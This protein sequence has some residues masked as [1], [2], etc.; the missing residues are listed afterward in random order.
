MDSPPFGP[1]LATA[2]R[3]AG[4]AARRVARRVRFRRRLRLGRGRIRA[5]WWGIAQSAV[6]GA[7]AWELAERPLH[8]QAPFFASVAAIVCLSTSY[9]NRLRR[10]IEMGI[11]V[12][13]GVGLGDLLVGVIGHGSIQLGFTV[14]IA[15]TVALLLDGGAMIVNQ[16]ALQAVFVV[17]LPPPTGG[18]VGRWEDAVVGGLVAL[19]IAFA[20]PADPR[21]SL[22]R[23]VDD[24]VHTLARALRLGADAA[25]GGDGEEAYEALEVARSAATVLDSWRSSVRAGQDITRLSPLRRSGSREVAA[26]QRAMEPIDSAV[27]NVR[28]ALRRLVVVIEEGSLRGEP[29]LESLVD[30]LEHLAG[31]LFTIP[32]SLRDPDGEGGRRAVVALTRVAEF[33]DPG[34]VAG[35]GLSP[36][37]VLAQLRSAVIDL[38]GVVGVEHG[39]ARQLLP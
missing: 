18:Y 39:V 8:H 22:R 35:R 11:G 4:R 28:V 20:A 15:M 7:A 12:A 33:L 2:P 21:P 9:L 36:A 32:G 13:L 30:A 25:R 24:V 6:G 5:S 38:L 3:T 14:L 26:H 16:A 37:V 31:A 17:A 34:T 29:G 23:D 27:R 19:T 1:G 10:V